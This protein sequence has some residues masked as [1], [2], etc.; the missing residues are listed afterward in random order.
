[1]SWIPTTNHVAGTYF[2]PALQGY[3]GGNIQTEQLFDPLRDD[4][5]P[6]RI[7]TQQRFWVDSIGLVHSDQEHLQ[8]Q[9]YTWS[10][11]TMELGRWKDFY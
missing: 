3:N 10:H 11:P 9:A 8:I 5:Q 4:Y 7:A 2:N 6:P 1:M